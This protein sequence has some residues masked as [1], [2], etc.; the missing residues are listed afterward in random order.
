MPTNEKIYMR[1]YMKNYNLLNKTLEYKM[2]YYY[3]NK[4]KIKEQQRQYYHKYKY[5]ETK[6]HFLKKRINNK[7]KINYGYFVIEMN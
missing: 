4:E 2:N 1:E 7:L 3:R 6:S 5:D